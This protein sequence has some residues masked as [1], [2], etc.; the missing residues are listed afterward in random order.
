MD[1]ERIELPDG[2][3]WEVH[4]EVTYGMQRAFSKA[5]MVSVGA[6]AQ[7]SDIDIGDTDALKGAVLKNPNLIDIGAI[8]DAWLDE[9][10]VK[11]SFKGKHTSV[12]AAGMADKY[13][14]PVIDRMRVLYQVLDEEQMAN[15]GGK[16]PR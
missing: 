7:A 2:Q 11:W 14:K 1:T 15:L 9:G 12:S 13:V 4:V 5:Q 16:R 8:E 3:W 10:S 6:M